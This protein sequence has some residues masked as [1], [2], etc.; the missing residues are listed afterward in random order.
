MLSF[1]QLMRSLSL[2]YDQKATDKKRARSK[3]RR[4]LKGESSRFTGVVAHS[5]PCGVVLFLWPTLQGIAASAA[6]DTF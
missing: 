4:A 1:R 5:S 6:D 2:L 3:A